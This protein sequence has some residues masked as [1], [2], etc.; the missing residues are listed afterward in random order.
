MKITF[1]SALM[2][3][4]ILIQVTATSRTPEERAARREERRLRKQLANNFPVVPQVPSL[5]PQTL[6]SPVTSPI[7]SCPQ[8]TQ[9]TRIRDCAFVTD[10]NPG[11]RCVLEF[12]TRG[13]CCPVQ[14]QPQQPQ[15]R[16]PL[17]PV[18]ANPLSGFKLPFISPLDIS[19]ALQQANQFLSNMRNTEQ[20]LAARRL[21]AAPN[22][23]EDR[24]QNFLGNNRQ[25]IKLNGIGLMVMK[26]MKAL[27]N[28][29][30]LNV[31][32]AQ[33]ALEKVPV[34]QINSVT[35]SCPRSVGCFDSKYRSVDGSCNNL[36]N[37]GW[38][39]AFTAYN[40]FLV[41]E[42]GDGFET[43]R[44]TGSSGQ[45]LPS[46]RLVSFTVGPEANAN[47]QRLSN[48]AM[49]WGQFLDHDLTS[50]ATTRSQDGKSIQC[51]GPEFDQNPSLLHPECFAIDIPANDPFYAQEQR[52]CMS[53]VRSA[54]AP[55]PG[56]SFG[57][58]EQLNQLS[59]YIDG[60]MIYG[61]SDE[62]LNGLRLF[63]NGLLK[64]SQVD[65]QQF[66]PQSNS[67]CG[68]PSERRQKC[69]FAG[70]GRSNVQANLVVLHALFV[71]HHNNVAQ[72]LQ[73]LNPQWDD[74]TVFQEARRIVGAQIQ[75]VTYN[76]FLPIV[77]GNS[78]MDRMGL[79]LS[80]SYSNSYD[81]SVDAQIISSF[82]TAAYRMHT[83]IPKTIDFADQS[84]S[85]VGSIDLSETYNNPSVLYESRSFERLTNGLTSQSSGDFDQFHTDQIS[86]HLFRPFGSSSGLDL[87]AINIQRGRDHG[88][89]GYNKFRSSCG[90]LPFTAWSQMSNEMRPGAAEKI[91]SLY[92][93]PDD[94]D[95]YIA[96]VSENPVADGI[97]GPTF[98]C[99]LSE[100][101]RRLKNGDR[102]WYENSGFRHS[103]TPQQLSELKKTSLASILCESG[104]SITQVQPFVLLKPDN[105]GNSRLRCEDI[106]RPDLTAWTNEP[107]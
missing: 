11:Q 32:Q 100:Q 101:F 2:I 53:F 34:A 80:E 102:F 72:Q 27:A 89:P 35:G 25:A 29:L 73:Q 107:L 104:P 61:K 39:Q 42:Y 64:T 90:L 22:S 54:S 94:V 70:D 12:N 69:F 38:G 18:P 51:C 75:H 52:T 66:L 1:V 82:A 13:V 33:Q 21:F 98:S 7:G 62:T 49:Q 79:R 86:N 63:R 87:V 10:Q 20:M 60:G 55:R 88:L 8:Q 103:F 23:N 3:T 56:C 76:E 97:V 5:L 59:A 57:P 24:H 50:A 16:N 81:A 36:Q 41:P 44:T 17:L 74:E 46:A 19:K 99:I 84:G 40:R 83:M 67:N 4:L 28:L 6:P 95:L 45:T 68:I 77:I 30:G 37:T 65:G 31:E 15:Q 26:F 93:S 106:P 85:T 58:R 48:M 91:Q 43:P 71:R 9:C 14:D 47:S 96:G 92:A 78:E 105:S